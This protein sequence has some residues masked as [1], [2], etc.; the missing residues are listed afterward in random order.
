[1]M[2]SRQGEWLLQRSLLEVMLDIRELLGVELYLSPPVQVP[3]PDPEPEPE[4]PRPPR[5]PVYRVPHHE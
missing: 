3:P 4:P 1:M 2:G 5:L